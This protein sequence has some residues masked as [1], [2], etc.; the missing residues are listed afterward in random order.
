MSHLPS[1]QSISFR[2]LKQHAEKI[3]EVEYLPVVQQLFIDSLFEEYCLVFAQSKKMPG[4]NA[5][6]HFCFFL[7]DK[8]NVYN[9]LLLRRYYCL[10]SF[11]LLVVK[12]P[13][14]I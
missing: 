14:Y 5:D 12:V 9:T 8:H 13:E 2:L 7:H 6:V 11:A 3:Q 4:S 1:V 10:E